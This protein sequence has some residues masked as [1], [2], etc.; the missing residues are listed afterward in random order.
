VGAFIFLGLAA[1]DG[2]NDL[3]SISGADH[4]FRVSAAR[5]DLAVFFYRDSLALQRQLAD[6]IGHPGRRRPADVRCA[7]EGNRD[8]QRRAVVT[9][10]EIITPGAEFKRGRAA[11]ARS[12]VAAPTPS[13][14]SAASLL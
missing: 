11:G 4:G 7:I 13:C 6:E 9:E 3:D 1:A 10:L 14:D 5:N 12:N 8:H 2:G